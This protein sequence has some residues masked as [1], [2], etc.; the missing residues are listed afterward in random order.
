MKEIKVG[1]YVQILSAVG[2]T[3]A[4]VE[5]VYPNYGLPN[6]QRC[7]VVNVSGVSVPVSEDQVLMVLTKAEYD[8]RRV[9]LGPFHTGDWDPFDEAA[10]AHDDA[11]QRQIDG[12]PHDRP[13]TYTGKFIRDVA[14]TT[15]KGVYAVIFGIPYAVIGGI[16]GLIRGNSRLTR[17]EIDRIE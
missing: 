10:K 3:W 4:A 5:I 7:L 16:V 15:A 2:R 12:L 13:I 14:I 17:E 9:G 6:A 8:D 11:M 1:D